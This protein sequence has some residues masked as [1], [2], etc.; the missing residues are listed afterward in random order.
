MDNSPSS[1]LV[2][3]APVHVLLPHEL[4]G[5]D[6]GCVLGED[7]PLHAVVPRLPPRLTL[8]A[9]NSLSKALRGSVLQ[10][11]LADNINQNN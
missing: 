5:H 6:D 2:Y 1:H 11:D 8:Q 10:P 9:G 7:D 4:P 3:T